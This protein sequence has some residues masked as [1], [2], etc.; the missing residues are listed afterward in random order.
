M[1]PCTVCKDH[2]PFTEYNKRA[3][4]PDGY[5]PMCK[6]CTRIKRKQYALSTGVTLDMREDVKPSV[7]TSVI[8]RMHNL[9]IVST[10]TR[11]EMLERV[12]E[13]I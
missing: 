5:T 6:P 2:K 12:K 11:N 3:E 8:E 10:P 4:A 9:G 7:Y 13:T 1:K